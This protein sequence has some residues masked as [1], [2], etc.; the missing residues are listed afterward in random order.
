MIPGTVH[1]ED[2]EKVPSNSLWYHLHLQW[3]CCT[4]SASGHIWPVAIATNGGGSLL[5]RWCQKFLIRQR[6]R[7]H[8]GVEHALPNLLLSLQKEKRVVILYSGVSKGCVYRTRW[9][10]PR[11]TSRICI[12]HHTDAGV[13][14]LSCSIFFWF[15]TQTTLHPNSL[16]CSW[17]VLFCQH[18]HICESFILNETNE[19]LLQNS[20]GSLSALWKLASWETALLSAPCFLIMRTSIFIHPYNGVDMVQRHNIWLPSCISRVPGHAIQHREVIFCK[21]WPEYFRA[22]VKQR[23]KKSNSLLTCPFCSC[24]IS[25]LPA[26]GGFRTEYCKKKEELTHAW[27]R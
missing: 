9:H 19:M 3:T 12:T 7:V 25:K 26:F 14:R 16:S 24:D 11:Y 2:N 23:K 22:F 5:C 17:S 18:L 6:Y 4:V 20:I 13:D 27:L 21:A 10:G 8:E 15:L 1:V